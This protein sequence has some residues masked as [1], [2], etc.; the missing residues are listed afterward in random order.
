[1]DTSPNEQSKF[2][3]SLFDW[4][5]AGGVSVCRCSDDAS[6]WQKPPLK[7]RLIVQLEKLVEDIKSGA[8]ASGAAVFLV[9]GP[10]NGKTHA[11]KYF[12]QQ[13]L[14]DAYE[15]VPADDNGV[16]SYSVT[17]VPGITSVRFIEDAS[18]GSSNDLVY[19][20]FVEDIEKFTI[21][22][23][24]NCLFICCVNR[25]I[26]ATVLARVA[27]KQMSASNEAV[28]FI[29]RLSSVVS[30]DATP[31]C[32]WPLE[33]ANAVYVHPMDEESLLEP[34]GENRPIAADIL[35]EICSADVGHCAECP[36][37]SLCPMRSNFRAMQD[38]ALRDN[39]LKVLRYFEIV[40][41][42]RLSFRDLFSIF[43]ILVV[44]NPYDYVSN[45]KRIQPCAWV[46]KQIEQVT[47]GQSAERLTALFELELMLYHN[48]LFSNWKDFKK[49]DRQLLRNIKSAKCD[50]ISGT[51]EFFKSLAA[52]IRRSANVSSQDYLE[53]C[54][55]LLD[56]ALQDTTQ[57]DD[58]PAV[59]AKE[60]K[61]VEDAYCKSLSLGIET[62]T[63]VSCHQK[64]EIENRFM[65]ECGRVELNANI[66][67][68][69]I[70]D[71]E[72]PLAQ[73]VISALRIVMSRVAKRSIGAANAFVYQ[74]S[75]LAEF[76]KLLANDGS[77][78]GKKRKICQAIQD[79]L[80]PDGKFTHSMLATFG[81]SEPDRENAFFL[82]SKTTPHFAFVATGHDNTTKNLLFVKEPSMGLM[83][84][85][86]FDLYSALV[87][88]QTG[89]S[90][91]S[92]PERI[93]DIFDGAKAR[94]QGYM[95]HHWDES[96]M[97]FSFPDRDKTFRVVQWNGD[98]GFYED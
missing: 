85:I 62:F 24:E 49:V 16:V 17:N 92:L 59:V 22:R 13:L 67:D 41:S 72:Y 46:A 57:M 8:V 73:T 61:D 9:G 79:Y 70:S 33:N 53:N 50:V 88:L 89:L 80:F 32:P 36:S 77:V 96:T 6:G 29:S 69:S 87:D 34:I 20:R 76:R 64:N 47:S 60:V 71:P 30:P 43:S 94:I 18:A 4:G 56:P 39:L 3:E 48:R 19:E 35:D 28:A 42:K 40:A 83:I 86:N 23:P 27:K 90:A 95:C 82:E 10:G 12:Q 58:L 91:A 11:A 2:P 75:R 38:P 84:K 78:P 98:E 1:M 44:G 63:S 15:Y 93:Y 26:L 14:G 55:Q 25:G 31:T 45:A 52:R 7:T 66:L 81:Q 65:Q 5:N 51:H 68:M 97:C 37:G 74:G 54:A 21:G